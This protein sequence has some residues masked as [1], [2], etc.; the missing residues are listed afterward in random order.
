VSLCF[1]FPPEPFFLCLAVTTFY[2]SWPP[3]VLFFVFFFRASCNS[4]GAWIGVSFIVAH[5]MLFLFLTLASLFCFYWMRFPFKKRKKEKTVSLFLHS[6][7]TQW[8]F[9]V[10]E[11]TQNEIFIVMGSKKE[12]SRDQVDMYRRKGLESRPEWLN[13]HSWPAAAA[14]SSAKSMAMSRNL[15]FPTESN[16]NSAS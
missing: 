3:N 2:S 1:Y 10:F 5:S 16:V 8:L 4:L 11:S 12:E 15:Q 9:K 6:A 7:G 14:F 13:R